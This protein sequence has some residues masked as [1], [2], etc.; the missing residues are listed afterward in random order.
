VVGDKSLPAEEGTGGGLAAAPRISVA[1]VNP[2]EVVAGRR[3]ARFG[4]LAVLR[5]P[6][7]GP[8]LGK[9]GVTVQMYALKST[10]AT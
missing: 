10:F 2:A 5:R 3:L 7:E 9:S 4:G 8:T 1:W 6:A